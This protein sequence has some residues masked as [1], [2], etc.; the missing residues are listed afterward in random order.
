MKAQQVRRWWWR[1]AK[2]KRGIL[3]PVSAF[4]YE[5]A[6]RCFSLAHYPS[7]AEL[8]RFDK[9]IVWKFFSHKGPALAVK[10]DQWP[11]ATSK[12]YAFLPV[13]WNLAASDNAL[14]EAFIEMVN[15]ERKRR[16]VKSQPPNKGNRHRPVSWGWL[17]LIDA[18]ENL[19]D[20]ERSH[21]SIALK[22]AEKLQ[23]EFILCW[24]EIEHQRRLRASL[25][26]PT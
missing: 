1:K 3:D 25:S 24:A 22:K 17:E 19:N 4:N 15:D 2:L 14:K 12:E 9:E 11:R 7:F 5:L 20:A 6:R 18:G 23:P 16:E 8:D 26:L 13:S 21:R 10:H